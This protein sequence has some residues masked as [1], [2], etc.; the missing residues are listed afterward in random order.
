M[1][2]NKRIKKIT[3]LFRCP[4]QSTIEELQLDNDDAAWGVFCEPD[5]IKFFNFLR[6]NLP[7]LQRLILAMHNKSDQR[8]SGDCVEDLIMQ[9]SLVIL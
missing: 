2:G 1:E 6:E 5:S 8:L 3:H 7:N 4:V 9:V